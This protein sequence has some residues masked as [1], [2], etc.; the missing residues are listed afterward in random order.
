M[1]T[2]DKIV[3]KRVPNLETLLEILA[4][5]D[6]FNEYDGGE[7]LLAYYVIPSRDKTSFYIKLVFNE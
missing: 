6:R 4:D 5:L 2:K 7:T 1:D 3:V